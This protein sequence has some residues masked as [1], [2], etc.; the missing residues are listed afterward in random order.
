MAPL[1]LGLKHTQTELNTGGVFVAY[2]TVMH[3]FIVPVTIVQ[4]STII[5]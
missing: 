3:V 1:S 4:S 2:L 5:I